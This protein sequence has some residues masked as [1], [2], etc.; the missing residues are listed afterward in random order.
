MMR[1]YCEILA[2]LGQ[3]ER[4]IATAPSVSLE[5]WSELCKRYADHLAHDD[6]L[7]AVGTAAPR[8]LLPLPT[9]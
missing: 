8:S 3:W 6:K 5:F 9:L 4:A 7:D 1:K 2:E